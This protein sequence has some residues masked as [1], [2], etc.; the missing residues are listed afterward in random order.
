[1]EEKVI[2][3]YRL[4]DWVTGVLKD[5]IES[6]IEEEPDEMTTFI[7]VNNILNNIE[8]LSTNKIPDYISED[9]TDKIFEEIKTSVDDM[10]EEES[11]DL[12]IMTRF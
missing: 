1:M 11:S 5:I 3:N 12:K 2:L 10:L 4:L 7:S 8:D 6:T 9:L